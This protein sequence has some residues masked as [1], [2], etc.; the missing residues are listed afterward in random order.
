[1]VVGDRL[2]T[3][4]FKE[5]K[6]QFHGVGN[7]LVRLLV[8]RAFKSDISDILTGCRCLSRRF[9]K[10][11]PVTSS[12]FEIE[13]EMTIHALDRGFLVREVPISYRDRAAE[14]SESKLNTVSDG[15]RVLRTIVVLFRDYRPLP[16]FG[17]VALLLFGVSFIMFLWP[18]DEYIKT[19]FVSKIPTLVVSIALGISSLLSLVSGVILDSIRMQARQFYELALTMMA[20][21]EHRA[22]R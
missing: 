6:R 8:N 4:Y 9:V 20:E 15:L 22:S 14:G 17:I 12:G 3:T 10:S 21:D 11:F 2:S 5:N 18:L 13:T 1:M 16:F 19:G 7:R